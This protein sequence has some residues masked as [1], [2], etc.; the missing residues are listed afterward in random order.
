MNKKKI[1]VL[2]EWYLPGNKAGGPV[3]SIFSLVSLLKNQFDFFIITTNCDLG[4]ERPYKDILPDTWSTH[5]EVPIYYFSKN[6]LNTTALAELINKINADSVYINSFWSYFF[7]IAILRLKKQKKISTEIILAPRGMLGKGAMSLKSFKKRLFLFYSKCINLYSG[8]IFHATNPDEE[9]DILKHLPNAKVKLAKNI[10]TMPVL[11]HKNT[12]KNT[13][14]LNLFYLSRITKVKNLLYALEILRELQTQDRV[15]YDIYG[16]IEDENYWS[17]CIDIIKNLPENI[18]VTYKGVLNFEEVQGVIN[19]YHFLFL[20]TLNENFGHSIYESLLNACPVIISDQTPWNNI[21][22]LNCG[23]VIDLKN[24][25]G[26][27]TALRSALS[28]D[29]KA[30][31]KMSENCLNFIKQNT[32]ADI[33][34][35][36]YQELFL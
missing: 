3:K 19:N 34:V 28:M 24:K 21:A 8:V 17:N 36:S 32:N 5:N 31:T 33:E 13:A 6:K 14:E 9:K 15:K 20:P 2:S 27:K 35:K 16:P 1:I 11:K 23:Y 30:Y 25:E 26:F 12:S 7:S 10:N 22:T 29:G 18:S 4:S